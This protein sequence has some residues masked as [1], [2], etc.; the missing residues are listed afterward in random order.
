M[1]SRQINFRLD[2]ASSHQLETII[3]WIS[4]SNT[5]QFLNKT[6]SSKNL[7][8]TPT[9]FVRLI[10]EASIEL[11]A[12][13]C[14]NDKIIKEIEYLFYKSADLS[15][16]LEILST[17]YSLSR[18][19]SEHLLVIAYKRFLTSQTSEVTEIE[20]ERR[21]NRIYSLYG[22]NES[23]VSEVLEEISEKI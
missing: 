13:D 17:K 23:D 12:I 11:L 15:I 3:E 5:F 14:E 10:V 1:D 6:F 19:V 7:T 16:I 8:S 22:I 9:T 21:I 18:T 4:S 20:D 2:T